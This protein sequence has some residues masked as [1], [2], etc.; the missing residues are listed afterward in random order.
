MFTKTCGIGSCGI[1]GQFISCSCTL[2]NESHILLRYLTIRV[3]QNDKHIVLRFIIVLQNR[4]L[5]TSKKNSY[6][7]ISGKLNFNRKK[8]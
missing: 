5:S 4:A 2:K 6:V 7:L 3:G 1:S 8:M